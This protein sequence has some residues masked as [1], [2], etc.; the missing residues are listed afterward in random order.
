MKSMASDLSGKQPKSESPAYNHLIWEKS[1]YLLQHAT[2][3][4]DWHPWGKEA[5]EQAVSEDKPVFLSIGY[6]TCHWCH[7]MAHE[8]FEDREVADLLNAGFVSIKVD[9]EE[10]P[11]I[12]SIYMEVC[13]MLTG[14]GGWPLTIVMTP[15]KLPFFA[16][17]YIPRETRFSLTGLLTL[18]PKISHAWNNQRGDL[19]HS[20]ETITGMLRKGSE[21]VPG[22]KPGPD[23][24]AEA[25]ED[26][27]VRFDPVYGGFGPAPKFP[28]PSTLV[29]LLRY[30]ERSGDRTSQG[31]VTATLDALRS[32]G[33]YDQ[34]GGG[35]HRYSTD[36]RWRVPHF[37][38]MLYDQALLLMAY[39]EA[40]QATRNEAYRKTADEIIAYVLR[41]LASPDGMFYSAEDAD[42]DGGEGAFY[43]WTNEEI[44]SV[45][46]A[47]DAA[48]ASLIFGVTARGNFSGAES[49]PGQN[50]LYLPKSPADQASSLQL[51]ESDLATRMGSVRKRLFDARGNRPRPSL[52]D[53][54]LTDWNALFIAALSQA[55]RVFHSP[56][57]LA[58]AERA[59]EGILSHMRAGDGGF[60][61][62]SRSGE[63]GIPA[64]L[65][66]YAFTIHALIELYETSFDIKYLVSAH[67]CMDYLIS[68]FWDSTNGGFY[69]LPDI[70]EQ[71]LV[72]KKE[73]YDG[74][75]PSGN[76]VAFLDLIRLTR[77]SG[78]TFYAEKASMLARCF[79]Q[80]VDR[81]PSS[82]SWFLCGLDLE[83]G[84]G[85]EVAIVGDPDAEDTRHLLS[86]IRCQYLPTA[87]VIFRPSGENGNAIAE[88][89]PF[90]RDLEMVDGKATAYVCSGN[91]CRLPVTRPEAL[92]ALIHEIRKR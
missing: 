39:T 92:P 57:Y 26:L 78:N 9:R 2:N 53:K 24:L 85:P 66:D 54:I 22:T 76:S 21:R 60:F 15:D 5:F 23:I 47:D 13:Q 6:A 17:T 8:S 71:L 70:A 63:A 48:F 83:T 45:L 74:A 58:T 87:T 61:H 14:S 82:F 27:R 38:K 80:D 30:G 62:R 73:I 16:A 64:F 72:R 42:S 59:M 90:I 44:L 51:T 40:Y 28:V 36:T 19:I 49:G 77:L 91:A 56:D 1:P 18:L 75:L 7:V 88:E 67:T 79:S 89:I 20:A 41:D 33:I 81:S 32:G 12:D 55:A 84:A 37:E 11:D 52:D 35:F 86:A 50:I 4:V 10:R 31:M 34:V 46:G 25:F 68:R 65:D 29:F 43:T 3:P 69:T